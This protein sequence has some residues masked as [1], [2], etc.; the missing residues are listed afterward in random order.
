MR[1]GRLRMAIFFILF[2]GSPAL[3]LHAVVPQKWEIRNY[4]DFLRGKFNGISISSEG[5][6]SLSPREEKIEGP[7]EEFYLSFLLA[8]DGTA[9]LG[10][11]HGGKVYKMDKEGK[12]EFYFQASEMDVTCLA[13]DKKGNLYAGTSPNGRIY[14]ITS[15]SKGEEF[16]NP[17]EK[18]IWDL[19]F[20]EEGNLLAAMGEGGGIYEINPLGEGKQ[21]LNVEEDHILCM[22]K[23]KNGDIIAGSGGG[24]LVYRLTKSGKI[25]IVFESPYEEVKNIALDEEGN[26]YAA[27]GGVFTKSKKDGVVSLAPER[28]V[29][30]T[31]SVTAVSVSQETSAGTERASSER[32]LGL[33]PTTQK[34]PGALYRISPEGIARRL[35]YSPEEL[36]Y[37]LFWNAAEKT[38]VFGTGNNGRL[39]ALDREEKASL[40]LQKNSE[41]VYAL[42]PFDSKI[43]LVSNNPSQLSVMYPEQR[44]DGEYLGYV[45]DTKTV[46]SWGRI[47]WNAELPVG[48][49]LRLQTRSGNSFEPNQTW[50]EWSPL[51]QKK[52]GEQILSPRARYLQFKVLFKTQSGRFSPALDRVSIFFLQTNMAP[53]ITSLELLDPNQVYLKPPEPEEIIWGLERRNP[54]RMDKKEEKISTLAMAKKVE[55]KGFQ[56]VKWDA[57]DEN[58]DTLQY[59]ISIRQEGERD[60]RVL[61]EKWEENLFA[62]DT[63]NF[64]DGVYYLKVE[65][66]DG[67][68]NPSELEKHS[69]KIS[70]PLVIDNTAPAIMNFK[71]AREKN[72]LDVTFQ[73]EDLLSAVKEV[74]YLIRP[75]EWGVVFPE[76]GICDSKQES[77]KFSA[78]LAPNADNMITIQVRDSYGN[79]AVF[80]H[81]F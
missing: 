41:Q 62:F 78:K 9:Y 64:P 58:E 48:S 69:D 54:N 34:E 8:P 30:G 70:R 1:N 29:D 53:V 6:L 33:S 59:A 21:V 31:I 46:S 66:S 13:L 44:F 11:G 81:I 57:S 32:P 27:A 42:I 19:L 5:I 76:D 73:V 17:S 18:Y 60:W 14:K 16:F 45:L 7:S 39:Y 80:R 25:S 68:S 3:W 65:A 35:W 40:L 75:G 12:V 2:I 49:I 47:S 71:A 79:T 63:V 4:E 28:S 67:P 43:Y 51:Y 50:S 55:R 72:I 38:L 26:I 23:A 56:T 52:E 77:F 24:G 36:I 37:C 74:K 61:E 15:P 22:K 20:T 10:T